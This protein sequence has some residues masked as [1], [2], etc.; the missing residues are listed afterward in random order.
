[1]NPLD[2]QLDRL[3]RSAARSPA[4]AALAELPFPAEARVLAAWRQSRREDAAWLGAWLRIGLATAA[5]TAA[6]ALA[7]NWSYLRP[8]PTDEFDVANATLYVAVA[9]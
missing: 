3:L 4:P 1:M 2:S 5:V 6:V 8:L 9:P 7:V